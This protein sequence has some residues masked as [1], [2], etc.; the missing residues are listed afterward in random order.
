M[1]EH[2]FSDE[3]MRLAEL[4]HQFLALSDDDDNAGRIIL[5]GPNGEYIGESKLSARD[6]AAATTAL[7]S[8]NDYRQEAEDAAL[9]AQAQPLPEVDDADV[10]ELVRTLEDLA[11]GGPLQ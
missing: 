5:R 1:N 11:N 2:P 7:T 9:A 8:V 10:K 3:E 4:L 6:I